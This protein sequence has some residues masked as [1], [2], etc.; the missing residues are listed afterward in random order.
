MQENNKVNNNFVNNNVSENLDND[1]NNNKN[2]NKKVY[3][4]QWEILRDGKIKKENLDDWFSNYGPK[5]ISRDSN[6]Y[7]KKVEFNV[8]IDN[9]ELEVF[10]VGSF[11][12]WCKNPD[13]LEKYHL[14][15]DKHS[16]MAKIVIENISHKD[17]YKFLIYNS[18][19]KEHM[20]LQ[21]PAGVY[22]N[23]FG[24]TIFWDFNDPSCYIQKYDLIDTFN[25]STKILQTDLPGLI[26][27]Y[28]NKEGVCGRDVNPKD[29]YRFI[30]DC[31]VIDEIKRLGFNSIQFL[32][33]AQSIDGD[34]WK[35]RYLVPFQ[36]AIQKNWGTPDD[37]A[38]M[39]DMFHKAG[40]AVIGDFVL[41]HLPHKDFQIFGQSFNAHGIH[42]W[43]KI[44][45]GKYKN[46][47]YLKEETSWGTMRI[48][49]DNFYV[50]DF[51]VSSCIHFMKYYKVDG[52]RID[53]IDG[54]IRYGPN[55]DGDERPNGRTFLRELNSTIY[56]YNSY[57]IINYEAHYF[58]EDNAKM[59]VAP[60]SLE[61][62]ALGAI[63]YNSSRLTY[64]FHTKYMFN[65]SEEI[66]VWKFKYITDEK[67]WGKSSSTIADFHNHDAAAG[68]MDNRCTGSYAYDAMME[69]SSSNHIH[70]IGKMKVMEAIISFGCEGRTLDL[71]QTFLLQSGTFEHNS[72]IEWFLTFNEVNRALVDYKKDVNFLMDNPAF[73]PAFT[74]NRE[75]LNVDDN[76]KVLV[77]QR[78]VDEEGY[79]SRYIIVIN[80]S[81]WRHLDYRVGVKS[82]KKYKVVL[83]S[84]K[85]CYGGF[86][87]ISYPELLE[88]Q[89][90]NSFELLDKELVLSILPPYCV[91]V[92]ECLSD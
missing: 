7:A 25:R 66:S 52:F 33:F 67:E 89:K 82:G 51:F 38:Y 62:R 76:N 45:T 54:I 83:N 17:E 87:I 49:F 40:I 70:A 14:E 20:L 16:I 31:G 21:D 35:Y 36:Y 39:I 41:G 18:K 30:A 69:I 48:D 75:F 78:S 23:D 85:F 81:A 4:Y 47:L 79:N 88:V 90:S 44:P 26:V 24:N 64:Y 53:N 91:L 13:D 43:E 11:N 68:L 28:A 59:L 92:L 27:H 71:L 42:L 72:S 37:F 9:S 80:T 58:Y 84:D 10:L 3:D 60:L 22:F 57:A 74:K 29:F 86:G 19:T 32:P 1:I 5:V 6:G 46:L 77:I 50:R 34:N 61:P 63:A 56:S 8:L 2:N 55:G 65:A 12:N 15:K 73:W